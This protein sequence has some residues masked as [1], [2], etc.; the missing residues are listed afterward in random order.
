[1][2][3]END[4]LGKPYNLD[5]DAP[6]AKAH[7]FLVYKGKLMVGNQREEHERL[8][9]RLTG[10]DDN[11]N[12][13]FDGRIWTAPKI[14]TFWQWPKNLK[15]YLNNLVR[16]ASKQQG[17]KIDLNKWKLEVRDPNTR[18]LIYVKIADILSAEAEVILQGKSAVLKHLQSPMEK[19]RDPVPAGVGSSKRV[20]GSRPGESPVQTRY[21][22]SMNEA[23]E[24]RD[25]VIRAAAETVYADIV[26][27]AGTVRNW[28]KDNTFRLIRNDKSAMFFVDVS[29]IGKDVKELD[30]VL[31]ES[32]GRNYYH[33][34]K[35][36][37]TISRMP[38][39]LHNRLMT[40]TDSKQ[41]AAIFEKVMEYSKSTFIHEFIHYIDYTKRGLKKAGT[42]NRAIG[43][44]GD[45][46]DYFNSPEE[47][48][49]YYQQGAAQFEEWAKEVKR[50]P[51]FAEL[52]QRRVPQSFSEFIKSEF[53]PRNTQNRIFPIE[54]LGVLSAANKRK[55]IKRV[56]PLH[57]RLSKEIYK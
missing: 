26:K 28:E 47:M 22:L 23:S 46:V 6:A 40:A 16:E 13:S 57:K 12:Y 52:V 19:K 4:Y 27:K 1:M 49:A 43:G 33:I 3:N 24:L 35:N 45:N 2:L 5:Y 56:A 9:Y 54:W 7:P 48:N 30:L 14:I 21:R 17:I 34:E 31:R 25:R 53:N 18:N 29:K 36:I 42:D 20:R 11:D 41:I 51:S 50:D 37:I 8:M 39:M 10:I 38:T 55:F 15:S 44:V 32:G